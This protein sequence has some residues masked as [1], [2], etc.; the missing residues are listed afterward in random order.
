MPLP[1]ARSLSTVNPGT[2]R[3][4]H[5]VPLTLQTG[6]WGCGVLPLESVP[7]SSRR[8]APTADQGCGGPVLQAGCWVLFNGRVQGPGC[9]L[10]IPGGLMGSKHGAD[11]V[12]GPRSSVAWKPHWVEQPLTTAG[13]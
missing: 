9:L 8:S 5:R 11:G 6:G 4:T 13:K 1:A 7:T 2:P 3:A 12:L 10:S